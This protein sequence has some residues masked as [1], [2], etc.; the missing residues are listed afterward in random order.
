MK[1]ALRHLRNH[2]VIFG[3]RSHISDA[4]PTDNG[5]A[6]KNKRA[7]QQMRA[8]LRHLRNRTVIF[9]RHSDI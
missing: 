1:A 4:A 3:R 6:P 8:A 5:G 2:T 9:G 7:R